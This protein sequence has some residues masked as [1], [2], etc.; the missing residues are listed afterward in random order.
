MQYSIHTS[1][2]HPMIN[3]ISER[4][5]SHVQNILEKR[6]DHTECQ[7]KHQTHNTDKT[8]NSRVFSR[9]DLIDLHT[10]KMFF[11]FFWFHNRFITD[12]FNKIKTHMCD[13][14]CSVQTTFVFHLFNNML[15]H[16]FLVLIQIQTVHDQLITFRKFCCCKANRDSC[17]F[18]MVFDQM[19]DCME[20][21]MYCSAIFISIAKIDDLW[22]FL[23]FCHMK[24]MLNQLINSLILGC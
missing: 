7:E 4:C 18:G 24:C 14:C 2:R 6:T 20:A 15:Q 5:D 16:F 19:H 17:C 13:C 1:S 12:F 3:D 23:I 10:A 9:E 11:T 21:S 8:W 22:F